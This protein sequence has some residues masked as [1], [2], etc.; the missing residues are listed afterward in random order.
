MLDAQLD[1]L[2][3]ISDRCVI[4]LQF[5]VHKTSVLVYYWVAVIQFHR[6]VEVTQRFL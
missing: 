6:A 2:R 3:V 5:A 1:F 4:L